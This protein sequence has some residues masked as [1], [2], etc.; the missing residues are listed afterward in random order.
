LVK[1]EAW[2]DV[3]AL[4]SGIAG[5][6]IYDFVGNSNQRVD[7]SNVLANFWGQKLGGNSK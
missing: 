4:G 1:S 7:V 2:F 6:A 5:R 3:A